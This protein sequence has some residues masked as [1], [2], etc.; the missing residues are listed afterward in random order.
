MA[1]VRLTAWQAQFLTINYGHLKGG[2][3][4]GEGLR[5][6]LWFL[7]VTVWQAPFLKTYTRN[8]FSMICGT[9]LIELSSNSH[10]RDLLEMLH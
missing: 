9:S 6:Q 4:T 1:I 2:D 7:A 8:P 5:N 3:L 10:T